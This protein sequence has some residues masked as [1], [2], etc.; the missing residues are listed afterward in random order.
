MDLSIAEEEVTEFFYTIE[1]LTESQISGLYLAVHAF[2]RSE[3]TNQVWKDILE[4]IEDVL[5]QMDNEI[6]QRNNDL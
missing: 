3:W 5:W 2:R 6:S 1:G 4:N